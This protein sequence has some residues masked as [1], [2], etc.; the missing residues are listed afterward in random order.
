MSL[1]NDIRLGIACDSIKPESIVGRTA[2]VV[3]HPGKM[4]LFPFVHWFE[5]RYAGRFRFPRLMF[6]ADLFIIGL[7]LG[8]LATGLLF[9]FSHPVDFEDRI[10]FQATVAPHEVITGAPSTLIIHYTNGTGEELRHAKLLLGF[11]AHFL[12]Q[13][14]S[15][16]LAN[17]TAHHT[18]DL[19]TVPVGAEGFVKIRGVMFG[20][21]GG[22][23]TFRSMLT[24]THGIHDTLGQKIDFQ[25]FSPL[26]S[27]LTLRLEISSRLIAH[28][29]IS[30]TVTYKN[31]GGIDF[32][33]LALEPIWPKGFVWRESS[34][35]L[36]NG[37]VPLPAIRAGASGTWSFRG[38]LGDAEEHA[39][40][41]IR[42]SFSFDHERYHQE[43]LVFER[44]V[45]LPPLHLSHTLPQ[46]AVRPGEV[47]E[48]MV[49][50]ENKGDI[51]LLN[52]VIGFE[53]D[54]P[55]FADHVYVVDAK[56]DARLK[57][58]EPGA[59]GTVIVRARLKPFIQQSDIPE[60]GQ[61]RIIT[62]AFASYRMSD[63]GTPIIS[64]GADV[65]SAPI[66]PFTLNAL[67]RYVAPSG[68]Q[69]GRGP[70]PPIVGEETRYWIFWTLR[71]TISPIERVRIQ[72]RLPVNVRFTGRQTV[73]QGNGM[74]YD[75]GTRMV[76]WGAD[77]IEPT[78]PAHSRV[79]GVAFEVALRPEQN[80]IG[81]F[82][83]LLIESDAAG[84][85]MN[86]GAILTAGAKT[87]T[88]DLPDDALALGLGKVV[89]ETLQRKF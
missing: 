25:T 77:R 28:Q 58:L 30:G 15:T 10:A 56:T 85:D 16:D 84:V 83:P 76:V 49:A 21:V 70:L 75:T 51:P 34:I 52:A 8:L 38:V 71:N 41:E 5:K 17:L 29:S 9:T 86:T 65:S 12:L 40:F 74:T 80:Q 36:R 1:L 27:A 73:S 88:T 53:T 62:H 43:T 47:A 63:D 60:N 6:S 2:C 14:L 32:P 87:I 79:V 82:A 35:P 72:G 78:L 54:S 11:P 23:Q 39:R 67:G 3:A 24:F 69:I 66:T 59:Q 64:R 57:R 4:V 33:E 68:D 89:E 44:P 55:L 20:D 31:T 61:V 26:R 45:A 22:K 42:P 50:Y 7:S 18:V 48:A 19:G 81:H 13:E 46:D 37:L